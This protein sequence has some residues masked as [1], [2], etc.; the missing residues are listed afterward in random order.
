MFRASS[1]GLLVLWCLFGAIE[2]QAHPFAI[3]LKVRA[4]KASQTAHAQTAAL[5]VNPK[6]RGTLTVKA[7]ASLTVTWTMRNTATTATVKNVL[8]HFFVVKEPKAGQATV[9]KLNKDVVLESALTLDF[10][11]GD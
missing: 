4:G 10:K 11:P 8:V 1:I 9:P 6:E 2:A 7:G 5:G 3:D